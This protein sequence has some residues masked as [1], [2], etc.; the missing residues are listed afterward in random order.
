MCHPAQDVALRFDAGWLAW[1]FSNVRSEHNPFEVATLSP[2]LLQRRAKGSWG[3]LGCECGRHTGVSLKQTEIPEASKLLQSQWACEGHRAA[4]PAPTWPAEIAFYSLGI[5]RAPDAP[6]TAL[7]CSPPR[8]KLRKP[9]RHQCSIRS[10]WTL[11]K[12]DT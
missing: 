7:P 11:I 1:H 8:D 2:R 5:A 9:S 6:A 3:F 12:I 10:S 4:W